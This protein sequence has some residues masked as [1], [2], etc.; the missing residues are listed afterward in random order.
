[1]SPTSLNF[2]NHDEGVSSAA[3]TI[4]LTN[5]QNST[6]TNISVTTTSTDY[7]QTNTCGTSIDAGEKCTITVTF[8]PSIMGTD[9]ATLSISDSAANSPQTAALTGTGLAPVKLTP[10]SET[11]PSQPVGATST[12]KVFTL[13]NYLTTTLSEI[14]PGTSGDFHI[15]STTCGTTLAAKGKCTINVVFQPTATGARTG[16]LSVSDSAANSPQTS[17]LTGTGK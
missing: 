1:L 14:V 12:A 4:T 17:Q 5:Y 9:D 3:K 13:T 11:Y 10:A 2:G 6:L 7:T 16:T 15:S 8:K